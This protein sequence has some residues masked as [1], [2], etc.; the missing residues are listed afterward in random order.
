M[1]IN[2]TAIV[3]LPSR[4]RVYIKKHYSKNTVETEDGTLFKNLVVTKR[5]IYC[6]WEYLTNAEVSALLS[7]LE[8]TFV[9]VEYPDPKTGEPR[10]GTFHSD[11]GE[12]D[13]TGLDEN[14]EAIGWED[15]TCTFTEQQGET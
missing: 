13:L 2:G 4:I 15:F 1:K 14:L 7:Q 9:E 3:V 11:T 6:D 5:T 12:T 8:N 10:T